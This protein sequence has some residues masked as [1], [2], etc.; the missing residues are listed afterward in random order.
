MPLPPDVGNAI[1]SYLRCRPQSGSR[2]LF[3]RS[4]EPFTGLCRSS[5]VSS[6]VRD[7]FRRAGIDSERQGAHQ[8]RHTLATE[9]L[10][11]GASTE[12]IAELLRH[13]SVECTTIYA[14]VDLV[15]LQAV[16]L[17]WPGGATK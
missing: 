12:E 14:K 8:F 6:I 16:G 13:Q 15:S 17:P 3:L 10:R 4:L 1:S 2:F 5:S 9:L 11:N 7:A